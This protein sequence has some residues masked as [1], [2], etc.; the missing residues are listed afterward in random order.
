MKDV[1][2][3]MPLQPTEGRLR[4]EEM[5]GLQTT[6]FFARTVDEGTQEAEGEG[7]GVQPARQQM[8]GQVRILPRECST[9]NKMRWPVRYQ[10]SRVPF[11][12]L[13]QVRVHASDIRQLMYLLR[14]CLNAIAYCACDASR[15]DLSHFGRGLGHSPILSSSSREPEP[16][17]L[18]GHVFDECPPTTLY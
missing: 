14:T 6:R 7:S 9:V 15:G 5:S 18:S 16:F 2:C 4:R 17:I 3:K 10:T 12:M 11:V 1:N 8:R 13:L